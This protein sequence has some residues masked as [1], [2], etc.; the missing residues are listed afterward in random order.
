MASNSSIIPLLLPE[1]ELLCPICQTLLKNPV[2]IPCGHNFCMTCISKHWK[3]AFASIFCPYCRRE[4]PSKPVLKTNTVLCA[5]MEHVGKV[6]PTSEIV[7]VPDEKPICNICEEGR[8]LS[9]VKTCVTC[10]ASFCSV[11]ATPHTTSQALAKHCMCTPVSDIKDLLCKKHSKVLEVFCM[12]HG[13]AICWQCTAKHPKCNICSVEEMRTDWKAAIE[14]VATEAQDRKKATSELLEALNTMSEGIKNAAVKMTEDMQLCFE[15]LMNTINHAQDRAISFIEAEK[16]EALQKTEKQKERLD[17]H[18][19]SISLLM[20][21]IDE[22]INNDSYFNFLL[23]LPLL[24][25]EVGQL[26]D[27]QLDGQ[28]VER[29]ILDIQQLN[30]SLESQLSTMLQRREEI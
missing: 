26:Q 16:M 6:F 1:D 15:A 4:F 25:A 17:D 18:L 29:M 11:H 21:K 14:P 10:L 2:T 28:A 22:C 23:P 3:L 13:A 30:S 27:V 8:E 9:A 19:L 20:D 7:L 5:I 24:P 12:N